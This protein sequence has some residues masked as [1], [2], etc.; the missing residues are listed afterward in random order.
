MG[1][2]LAFEQKLTN[3]EMEWLESINFRFNSFE[4]VYEEADFND[5]LRRLI[6]YEE[7]NKTNYQ[8][9]KK[10]NLDPE[11]GAWVTMI[12]RLGRD[13]IEAE[14]RQLLDDINFAWVSTR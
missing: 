2:R 13:G 4:E 7:A 8:I 5:C 12:R 6:E 1:R 11:L 14:R 3:V 9:P 10:Y